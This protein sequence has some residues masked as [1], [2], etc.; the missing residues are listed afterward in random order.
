MLLCVCMCVTFYSLPLQI[1]P[2]GIGHISVFKG[3]C[4][5]QM[6]TALYVPSPPSLKKNRV[7]TIAAFFKTSYLTSPASTTY[8]SSS[9]PPQF[10]CCLTHTNCSFF[11]QL[12]STLWQKQR[13][14]H[15]KSSS[16]GHLTIFCVKGVNVCCVK[17][18]EGFLPQHAVASKNNLYSL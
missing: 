3:L 16:G 10:I 12:T 1:L 5:V 6:A 8:I 17:G 18:W 14:A 2:T 13:W 7:A 11:H 15:S 4:C 9:I